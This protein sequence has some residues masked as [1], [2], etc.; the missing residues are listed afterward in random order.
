KAQA[1]IARAPGSSSGL[2]NSYIK[3]SNAAVFISSEAKTDAALKRTFSTSSPKHFK[4]GS[5]ER[6][7]PNLS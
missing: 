3:G 1:A 4:I 2:F 6:G 5:T 7:S